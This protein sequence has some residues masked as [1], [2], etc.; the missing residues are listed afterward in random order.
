MPASKNLQDLLGKPAS[1]QA[2]MT[3][4]S[5]NA[6]KSGMGLP[7]GSD[8]GSGNPLAKMDE[9]SKKKPEKGKTS[10]SLDADVL[11]TLFMTG[12]N[13]EGMF[14]PKVD[15]EN[16]DE[17][18]VPLHE[19]QDE[20]AKAKIDGNK[21]E[22]KGKYKKQFQ[23]DFMK[24]PDQ[25]EIVTPKGKMTVAE[26]M[27]KGYDPLTKT[28]RKEHDQENLKKKHLDRVND[29]DKAKLEELTNPKAANI[30]PADAEKFGLKEDSPFVK[31]PESLAQGA[32]APMP[33][34]PAMAKLTGGGPVGA[35]TT[36]PPQESQAAGG[37]D[38]S[39]L[40][41]GK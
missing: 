10:A 35:P 23:K 21:V 9:L 39:A 20:D 14:S 24:H 27:R 1:E 22:P 34:T 6:V 2:G 26:A 12:D 16:P 41:G 15:E 25:Y 37:I 38:L 32:S 8:D 33:E 7:N 5:A 29:A 17:T 4:D 11:N 28:F 3:E 18:H 36:E 40:L 19:E 31:Q 30:A 13:T